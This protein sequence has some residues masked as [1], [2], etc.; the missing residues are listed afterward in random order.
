MKTCPKCNGSGYLKGFTHVENGIC[1]CCLGSG[2][3]EGE[4]NKEKNIAND[5]RLAYWNEEKEKQNK[6][7]EEIKETYKG[8]IKLVKTE[9]ETEYNT[10]EYKVYYADFKTKKWTYSCCLKKHKLEGVKRAV[11]KSNKTR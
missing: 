6:L 10:A 7:I 1:F 8:I 2:K 11:E 5:E 4:E 9:E 3:V